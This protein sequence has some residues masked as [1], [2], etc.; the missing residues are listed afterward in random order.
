MYLKS[1]L[2]IVLNFNPFMTFTDDPRPEY[3]DQVL[4]KITQTC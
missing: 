3:Q 4:Y 2:P 1:R